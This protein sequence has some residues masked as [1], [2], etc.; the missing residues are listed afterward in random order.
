LRWCAAIFARTARIPSGSATNRLLRTLGNWTPCDL[1]VE[2]AVLVRVHTRCTAGDV[3]AADCRCR[4]TLDQSMRMIAEEGCGV[5]LYLHNTSRGFEIDRAP[6]SAEAIR[7]GER[8]CLAGRTGGKH[9]PA[10]PAPGAARARRLAGTHVG[11]ILRAIGLGGQRRSL[12]PPY[13]HEERLDSL[14]VHLVNPSDN[15]FG[16]A[17]ITPRWLF[18][19]AAATPQIAGDPI[20]VDE[21]LE[22]IV[23][24]TISRETLSASACIPAMRCAATRWGGWRASR[25]AWVIYGGI[26][27]TLF[28]EEAL[29]R[30][31]GA[32]R[33]DRA[34]AMLPGAGQSPIA[35]PASR[36]ESTTADGLKA[37]SFWPRAGT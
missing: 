6:V 5:V 34:M 1:L 36:K 23:P 14:S 19:L 37:A 26:H 16:T 13:S 28:P 35:W 2:H 24:E 12:R 27:A 10:H 8:G 33:G 25:G 7:A 15:S 32:R 29:E 17:V 22:Q 18:V 20:L 3:F 21:S 11:A 4:E 31:S 9:G 30:G